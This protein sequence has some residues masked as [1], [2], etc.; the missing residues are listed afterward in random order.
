MHGRGVIQETRQ[1]YQA[2]HPELTVWDYN[3]LI[4]GLLYNVFYCQEEAE[5]FVEWIMNQMTPEMLASL[6]YDSDGFQDA[7][8]GKYIKETGGY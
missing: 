6:R 2:T 4:H 3:S 7:Y 1:K 5:D 8:G